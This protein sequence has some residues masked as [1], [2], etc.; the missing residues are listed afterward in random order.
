MAVAWH[1]ARQPAKPALITDAGTVT[2]GELNTRAN[3]L[4]RASSARHPARRRRC[5]AVLEPI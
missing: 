5:A 4:A 2:Y 1:A 3:R